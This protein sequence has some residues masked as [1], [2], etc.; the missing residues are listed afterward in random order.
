MRQ[1]V[2]LAPLSNEAL[3]QTD[4]DARARGTSDSR[5]G[6][7]NATWVTA[8]PTVG[9]ALPAERSLGPS[10]VSGFQDVHPAIETSAQARN[11]AARAELHTSPSAD[12]STPWRKQHV[13]LIVAEIDRAA[14]ERVEQGDE[15]APA[16]AR[17]IVG[18]IARAQAEPTN[19][20]RSRALGDEEPA[21]SPAART[22]PP[23]APSTKGRRVVV[24]WSVTV[25]Q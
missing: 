1:V 4:C 2:K 14:S 24:T 20:R 21:A 22:A 16:I 8:V 15:L 25:R 13:Q 11:R 6:A 17:G 5:P 3:M 19:E 23:A 9:R 18:Q 12:T 10:D 7:I